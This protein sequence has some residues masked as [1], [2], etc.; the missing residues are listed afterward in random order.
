MGVLRA[1]SGGW[2]GDCDF[3]SHFVGQIGTDCGVVCS[4]EALARCKNGSGKPLT[5]DVWFVIVK[6][7]NIHTDGTR[8]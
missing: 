8:G 4:Y 1:V 5:C 7:N 3:G 2:N 6:V